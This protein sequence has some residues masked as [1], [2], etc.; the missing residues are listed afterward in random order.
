MVDNAAA[1]QWA[2]QKAKWSA[3]RHIST[4]HFAVQ[5]WKKRGHLLPLKVDTTRQLAD[6]F[7]KALPHA[8]HALMRTLVMGRNDDSKYT[9]PRT[10]DLS[11][12][13]A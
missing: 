8:T 2:A 13:A 10:E 1:L 4:Q 9:L 12:A 7:T 6:L 5:D 11:A 3:S